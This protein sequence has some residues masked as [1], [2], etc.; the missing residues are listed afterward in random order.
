VGTNLESLQR[1]IDQTMA[2]DYA[3][4]ARELH[5]DLVV[6]EPPGLPHGGQ[7]RGRDASGTVKTIIR[8]HWDQQ[9]GEIQ[10]WEADDAVFSHRDITWT[11]KRT[12]K[13]VGTSVVERFDFRDGKIV[14]IDVF[15]DDVQ[16]LIGTLVP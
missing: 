13:S 14:C 15:I 16:G 5:E 6:D 7:W 10:Y 4:A 11:G 9:M 3:A 2:G 1:L 8:D 12:G